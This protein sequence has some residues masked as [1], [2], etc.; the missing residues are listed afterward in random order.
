MFFNQKEFVT[1]AKQLMKLGVPMVATQLFIMGM[2][3]VD[4][5]MAGRYSSKISR[6]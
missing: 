1:E 4:T 3:F 2:G 6:V 5:V